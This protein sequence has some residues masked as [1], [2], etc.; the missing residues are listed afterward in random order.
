MTTRDDNGSDS[1]HHPRTNLSLKVEYPDVESFLHDYTENISQGGTFVSSERTWAVG[2]TLRL[3]LSFPGLLKAIHLKG[4]VAWVRIGK[5]PGIGVEFVF[6]DDAE[7]PDS[8][9]RLSRLVGAI[10]RGERGTVARRVRVLVVEDNP[11]IIDLLEEGLSRM[12]ERDSSSEAVFAF[13]RAS[14]GAGALEM[15]ENEPI[16]VVISDFYLPV[17]DGETFIRKCRE[18]LG[19]ELPI[20]AVSAGGPEARRRALA[21]GADLF[22]SKPLRLVSVFETVT[23]LLGLAE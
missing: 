12:T 10:Q 3:T 17:L 15:I 14:D 11:L 9:I 2:D 5:D 13:A 4:Q 20:I 6:D 16:D 22:L 1:R 8:Q 21:A 23:D 7:A 19:P 18:L